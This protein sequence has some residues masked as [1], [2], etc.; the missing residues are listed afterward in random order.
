MNKKGYYRIAD[1]SMFILTMVI[2][3]VAIGMGIFIFYSHNVDVR[4][5]EAK[6]LSDT[7]VEVM[8]ESNLK[9]LDNLDIFEEAGLDR[10]V[11]TKSGY[12]YFK[13]EVFKDTFKKEI[14]GGEETELFDKTEF[15]K[16][17]EGGNDNFEV[18]C[19]LRSE[20]FPKC[21][22]RVIRIDNYRIKILTASNQLGKRV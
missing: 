11:I 4:E 2:I 6:I 12:Y 22:R 18:E 19:D 3:A 14:Y 16:K 9:D 1:I 20:K 17:F 15:I 13:V 21:N 8:F 5:Q 7:L 10:D